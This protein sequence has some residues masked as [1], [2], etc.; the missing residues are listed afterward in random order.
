MTA[1]APEIIE[2]GP[3]SKR[4]KPMLTCGFC[5]HGNCEHCPRM[6]I[7]FGK[8]W[9]CQCSREGCPSG[10]VRCCDCKDEDPDN[11]SPSDWRCYDKDAC[12]TR[13][14]K[15][16]DDNP[17]VQQIRT[18]KERVK[19]AETA[20]KAAK[21]E[22]APKEKT[23]CLVTGDE[24]KGGLFKPG[25]DARYVS[26]RVAE[27]LAGK[28]TETATLKRFD[29]EV[30]SDALK[31]KFVKSL[32]LQREAAEKRAAAAAEKAKAKT[33][34]DDK[35]AAKPAAKKAASAKG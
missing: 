12:A 7:F 33:K 18:I 13:V 8:R 28:A 20:E 3:R 4:R 17:L 31:A 30:G 22:K 1:P 14:Q 9:K 23:Y 29:D 16:L 24:T 27:V 15:R 26:L 25:M 32:G 10:T 5:Q 21:A 2:D 6:T 35:T 19:M 34:G 11:V